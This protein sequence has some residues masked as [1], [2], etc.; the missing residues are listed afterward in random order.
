MLYACAYNAA[1]GITMQ[2]AKRM[3]MS[4]QLANLGDTLEPLVAGNRTIP[5]FWAEE[6]SALEESQA[7]AFKGSVYRCAWGLRGVCCTSFAPNSCLVCEHQSSSCW[8]SWHNRV[9]SCTG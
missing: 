7:Q 2:A 5:I 6:A 9:S 4:S 3:M 1:A 8:Q